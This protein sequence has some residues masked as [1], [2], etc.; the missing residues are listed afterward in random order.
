MEKKRFKT[1][2]L[3]KKKTIP[4]P[5]YMKEVLALKEEIKELKEKVE[6]CESQIDSDAYDRAYNTCECDCCL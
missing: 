4:Y 3:R 5:I 6:E 1:N 2:T